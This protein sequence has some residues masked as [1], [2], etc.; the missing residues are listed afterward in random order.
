M[1]LTSPFFFFSVP[2]A[3]SAEKH[4][5][6]YERPGKI[7]LVV[8]LNIKIRVE[9]DL[10]PEFNRES[11]AHLFHSVLRM[12]LVARRSVATRFCIIEHVLTK[13][14]DDTKSMIQIATVR[15]ANFAITYI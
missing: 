11:F 7:Y 2:S 13:R 1:D 4:V 14:E 12:L 5:V 3:V 8:N 9:I 15:Q 10:D 6:A